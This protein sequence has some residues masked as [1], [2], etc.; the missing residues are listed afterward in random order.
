MLGRINIIGE[1]AK[2][3][4]HKDMLERKIARTSLNSYHHVLWSTYGILLVP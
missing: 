2:W 1:R 3:T 4:E